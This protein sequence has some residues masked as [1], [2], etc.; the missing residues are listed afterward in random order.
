MISSLAVE[1]LKFLSVP[2][3]R[4]FSLGF[5]KM[6]AGEGPGN[7]ETPVL[8]RPSLSSYAQPIFL[9]FQ[10]NRSLELRSSWG[11][12]RDPVPYSSSAMINSSNEVKDEVNRFTLRDIM[13][14]FFF[15]YLRLRPQRTK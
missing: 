8:A 11:I 5:T 7:Q 12:V 3:S 14:R 13:P 4:I 1:G 15:K 6:L 2:S 10:V 9:Q